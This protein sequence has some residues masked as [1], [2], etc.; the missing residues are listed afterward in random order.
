MEWLLGSVVIFSAGLIQG[1]TGFGLALVAVPCMLFFLP[2]TAVIPM[3]VILSGLNTVAVAIHARQHV[4][5]AIVVPLS[6][7]GVAGIPLGTLLLTHISPVPFKLAVGCLVSAFA[8]TLMLGWKRP[9]RNQK[10][11]LYPVGFFSGVLGGATSMSG[12]PV[13]LFLA[14]QGLAKDVF[15]ANIITYFVVLNI[16][17]IATFAVRGMFTVDVLRYAAAFIP[18]MLLGTWAGIHL[19]KHVP[20]AR[21]ARITMALVIIT[22]LVLV[23]TNTVA[24]MRGTV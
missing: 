1:C 23:I 22:G 12:P 5:R 16:A 24:M 15:R 3:V 18:M 9:L 11:G 2:Q 20:E 10:A 19:A 6:I 13:I 8:L 7:T 14:N 21:F 17:A 4:Q